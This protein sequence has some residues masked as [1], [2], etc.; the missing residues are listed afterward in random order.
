MIYA[1]KAWVS[2]QHCKEPKMPHFACGNCGAYKDRQA[3]VVVE[4]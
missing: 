3:R 1:P 4:S 2:C